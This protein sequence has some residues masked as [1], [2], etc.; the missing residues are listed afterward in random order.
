MVGGGAGAEAKASIVSVVGCRV[1]GFWVVHA[2]CHSTIVSWSRAV[3]LYPYGLVL[4]KGLD[5]SRT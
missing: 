1:L 3:G 4:R 2:P 5:V